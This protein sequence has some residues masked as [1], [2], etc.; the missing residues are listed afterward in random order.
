MDLSRPTLYRLLYTL[1]TKGF[2]SSVGDPQRFRLGPA[3]AKLSQVWTQTVDLSQ[4]TE[5][6]MR[7]LWNETQETVGLWVRQGE[8][9]FCV[10]ELPSPQPLNLERGVGSNERI[11]RGA[12]GRAILA[13]SE[14]AESDLQG[15]ASVV[16]MSVT[17]FRN[18]LKATRERGYA[19][20]AT[21][22]P[23]PSRWP[24]R[25]PT[26]CRAPCGRATKTT[27]LR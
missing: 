25:L 18:E 15:H 27:R 19:C 7:R 4:I 13:F 20:S 5:P 9:R 24:T 16:G 14:E 10:A 11:A 6:V 12:S 1:E 22:K 17:K 2:I 8:Q 26:A 23:K 3:V 21:T